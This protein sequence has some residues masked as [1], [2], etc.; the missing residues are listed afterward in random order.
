[1][2]HTPVASLE[3]TLSAACSG[4]SFV[5]VSVKQSLLPLVHLAAAM[6]AALSNVAVRRKFLG[7]WCRRWHWIG[8]F[9]SVQ[10]K[11]RYVREALSYMLSHQW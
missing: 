1:M 8:W 10:L 4:V 7:C 11:S 9:L 2:Q 6:T 5:L 3:I